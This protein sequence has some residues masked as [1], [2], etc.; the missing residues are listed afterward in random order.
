LSYV[1]LFAGSADPPRLGN[2]SRKLSDLNEPRSTNWEI[3]IRI[4]L[5]NQT[6]LNRFSSKTLMHT[7]F[8]R[9]ITG[10]EPLDAIRDLRILTRCH[11][12]KRPVEEAIN[13]IWRQLEYKLNPLRYD[14][15]DVLSV[16]KWILAITIGLCLERSF[17]LSYQVFLFDDLTLRQI[18]NNGLYRFACEQLGA[19]S[20]EKFINAHPHVVKGLVFVMLGLFLFDAFRV[21]V[22]LPW[23]FKSFRKRNIELKTRQPFALPA[24]DVSKLAFISIATIYIFF[25]AAQTFFLINIYFLCLL[26]AQI[27]DFFWYISLTTLKLPKDPKVITDSA[28][29]KIRKWEEKLKIKLTTIIGKSIKEITRQHKIDQPSDVA[30]VTKA[31]GSLADF[32][33]DELSSLE[34][35]NAER[36]DEFR[37]Q[38]PRLL[39]KWKEYIQVKGQIEADVRVR[40]EGALIAGWK[41]VSCLAV[42][43]PQLPFHARVPT[44]IVLCIVALG[45][46][47]HIANIA[48]DYWRNHDEYYSTLILLYKPQT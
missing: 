14:A 18:E 47:S 48:Y 1:S 17:T 12:T 25:F 15:E 31:A 40:N 35:K 42:L 38:L 23:I 39:S 2:T 30:N 33:N 11:E 9:D 29:K 19:T 22:P 32:L 8:N 7:S 6:I 3:W 44:R 27:L 46:F 41:V 16:F 10:S 37:N 28:L 43:S 21:L 26:M 24:F 4:S 34:T 13:K 45:I 36:A 20:S 5:T